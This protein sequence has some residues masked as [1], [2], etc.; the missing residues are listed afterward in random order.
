MSSPKEDRGTPRRRAAARAQSR[1]HRYFGQPHERDMG[2]AND[3]PDVIAL[4]TSEGG[5]GLYSRPSPAKDVALRHGKRPV[6]VARVVATRAKKGE[7]L[8]SGWAIAGFLVDRKYAYIDGQED[9][10]AV[11]AKCVFCDAS[12][13]VKVSG[14]MQ[15][16]WTT[17]GRHLKS[18]HGIHGEE[19]LHKE[20]AKM[21][22]IAAE[23]G[24]VKV[25]PGINPYPARGREWKARVRALI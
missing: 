9:L 1:L 4:D 12:L 6:D 13:V 21:K 15:I 23:P 7:P 17:C 5:I 20:L 18:K 25:V 14:K 3:S 8:A 19:E 16:L 2:L 10:D 22:S 24:S 11:L